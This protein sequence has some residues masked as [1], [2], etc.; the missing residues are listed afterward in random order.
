MK[1]ADCH[2]FTLNHADVQAPHQPKTARDLIRKKPRRVSI[3]SLAST[4]PTPEQS[5]IHPLVPPPCIK[6]IPSLPFPSR[7]EINPSS[8]AKAKTFGSSLPPQEL[9]ARKAL[10][11][12][13]RR[14]LRP[15]INK[16]HIS[17]QNCQHRHGCLLPIAG[18][19]N[20]K[21]MET[22]VVLRRA[23]KLGNAAFFKLDD[24][25]SCSRTFLGNDTSDSHAGSIRGHE[26]SKMELNSELSN[27]DNFPV[28]ADLGIMPIKVMDIRSGHPFPPLFPSPRGGNSM[29]HAQWGFA[30]VRSDKT[31]C[32]IINLT[33]ART[34]SY[35]MSF[36]FSRS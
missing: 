5:E 19:L 13:S 16:D 8:P 30:E 10:L 4:S 20:G 27:Y 22:G 7:E 31:F 26:M 14:R 35:V 11:T 18:Y 29:E 12:T 21:L 6:R 36:L 32:T 24:P 1:M 3:A 33:I 28:S 9:L 17:P 23:D 2:D 15:V 34:F 25:S